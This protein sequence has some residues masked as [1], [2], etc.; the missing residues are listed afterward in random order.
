MEDDHDHSE[1]IVD[2]Y[3]HLIYSKL[4]QQ[5]Y[6]PTTT[7]MDYADS[8]YRQLYSYG[9][10]NYKQASL[11]VKENNNVNNRNKLTTQSVESEML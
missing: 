11:A 6:Q 9:P 5:P 8:D 1:I 2:H 3:A 10:M 7:D 4:L